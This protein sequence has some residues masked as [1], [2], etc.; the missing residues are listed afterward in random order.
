VQIVGGVLHVD[1]G[2][3][4]ARQPDDLDNL[5]IGD[6]ADMGAQREPAFAQ[7]PFYPVLFHA[8]PP[9]GGHHIGIGRRAS[10]RTIVRP[11]SCDTLQARQSRGK[12]TRLT[13]I[14]EPLCVLLVAFYLFSQFLDRFRIDLL[15]LVNQLFAGL[16]VALYE[17]VQTFFGNVE[18]TLSLVL[19]V[20]FSW[21]K[22]LPLG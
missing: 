15:R 1:E 12:S 18:R 10:A 11:H 22:P 16:G 13:F 19:H 2:G 17:L 7:Y 14:H 8:S 9:V 5:R 21:V 6:P 3:I 20:L 4:E